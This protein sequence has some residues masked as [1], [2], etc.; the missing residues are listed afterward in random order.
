MRKDDLI[1][2]QQ[3]Y[4]SDFR[5]LGD[6]SKYLQSLIVDVNRGIVRYRKQPI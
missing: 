5:L 1:I 2:R 4:M 3:I 6:S